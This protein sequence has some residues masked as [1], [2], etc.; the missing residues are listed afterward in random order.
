MSRYFFLPLPD[1]FLH[2]RRLGRLRLFIRRLFVAVVNV[3]ILTGI[4]FLTAYLVALGISAG[5]L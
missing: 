3:A 4:A 5:S 1:E 2:N